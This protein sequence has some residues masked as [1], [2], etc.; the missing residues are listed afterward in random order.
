[1]A[2]CLFYLLEEFQVK[3]Y[4]YTFWP[5]FRT[6]R[7][8]VMIRHQI[9]HKVELVYIYGPFYFGRKGDRQESVPC[10]THRA[11]TISWD[12]HMVPRSARYS[13]LSCNIFLWPH[14]VRF[15]AEAKRYQISNSRL[16]WVGSEITVAW[17]V[18]DCR[19]LGTFFSNTLRTAAAAAQYYS[20][21]HNWGSNKIFVPFCHSDYQNMIYWGSIWFPI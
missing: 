8:N 17:E 16:G 3:P 21:H 6:Q 18:T 10:D 11:G 2:P 20:L 5:F 7:T 9:L 15:A 4:Y 13:N 12:D 14:C 19:T 1:M